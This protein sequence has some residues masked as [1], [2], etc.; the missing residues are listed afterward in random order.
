MLTGI[1]IMES[2]PAGGFFFCREYGMIW[3]KESSYRSIDRQ[4]H[5]ISYFIKGFTK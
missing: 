3:R 2:L 1:L 5:T 4:K